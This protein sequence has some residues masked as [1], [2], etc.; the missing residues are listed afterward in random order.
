MTCFCFL[1]ACVG[2]RM[3]MFTTNAFNM[4]EAINKLWPPARKIIFV[5]VFE[6]SKSVTGNKIRLKMLDS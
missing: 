2:A 3:C 5:D 4:N 1:C 6:A